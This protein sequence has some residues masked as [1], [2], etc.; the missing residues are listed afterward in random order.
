MSPHLSS[1]LNN[2]APIKKFYIAIGSANI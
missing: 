1:D 2:L